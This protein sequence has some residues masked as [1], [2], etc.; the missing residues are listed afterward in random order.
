MPGYRGHTIG[1][2]FFCGILYVFPFWLPMSWMEKLACVSIAVFFGLWPDVDTKSKGQA[3]FLTGF[4]IA[5]V[6]LILREKFEI[7]AYMG[8]IIVLPILSRHRGWTHNP[9]GML[10]IP[11]GLYLAAVYLTGISPEILFPYFIAAVLGYCSH[12]VMDKYF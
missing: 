1:A 12:I 7:A 4:L 3:L 8:L 10:L 11:G 2:L 5:D 6:I 9:A